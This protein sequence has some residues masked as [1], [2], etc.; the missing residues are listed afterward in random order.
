MSIPDNDIEE[1][2]MEEPY[3]I[4]VPVFGRGK[5]VFLLIGMLVLAAFLLLLPAMAV[6]NSQIEIS[7]MSAFVLLSARISPHVFYPFTAVT[8][9]LGIA[10]LMNIWAFFARETL[11]IANRD[12]LFSRTIFGL[13]H[14]Y[15]LA[16]EYITK[17]VYIPSTL[18]IDPKKRDQTFKT[19]GF[20]EGKIAITCS[21]RVYRFGRALEDQQAA[22]LADEIDLLIRSR[23]IKT[24]QIPLTPAK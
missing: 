14:T 19:R 3:R 12:V 4:V 2:T 16:P 9:L 17:V 10:F 22:R 11:E 18:S 6:R 7:R 8:S 1:L 23:K 13:G 15:H 5:M 20:H 21:G 24:S